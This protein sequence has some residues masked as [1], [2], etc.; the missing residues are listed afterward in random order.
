MRNRAKCKLCNSVLESFGPDDFVTCS[1]GEIAIGP[2]LYAAARSWSNFLRVDDNDCEICV[3]YQENDNKKHNDVYKE[4]QAHA[5]TLEE[6]V[7]KL[8]DMIKTYKR[9]PEEAKNK[10]VTH[11]DHMSLLMLLSSLFKSI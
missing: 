11:A 4:E 9:L 2:K 5:T 8:E 6:F 3:S 10:P 7:S 1:C